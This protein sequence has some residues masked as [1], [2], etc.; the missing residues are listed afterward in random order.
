MFC[1]HEDEQNALKSLQKDVILSWR[2]PENHSVIS[3]RTLLSDRDQN[4]CDDFT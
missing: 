2:S 3:V 4:R 1:S